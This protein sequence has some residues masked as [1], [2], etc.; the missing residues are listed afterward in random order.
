MALFVFTYVSHSRFFSWLEALSIR[1]M[2]EQYKDAGGVLLVQPEHL[3]S[4]QQMGTEYAMTEGKSAAAKTLNLT[5][6]FLFG[7][8]RDIV[9]ESDENF[10]VKFELVYTMGLQQSADNSP[11]RWRT[12]QEVLG[13]I[14]T[15]APEVHN[16]FPD[17]IEIHPGRPGSFSRTRVLKSEAMERL[18]DGL[19][20]RVC[21]EGIT[22]LPIPRQTPAVR[23][24]V[25]T[26][27]TK[28]DLTPEEINN[29][30]GP[31]GFSSDAVRPTLVLLRGLVVSNV[32]AFTPMQKRWRVNYGTAP[33]RKPETR[34]A[35]PYR[36]KGQPSPRSEF[37]HPDVVI[38][39]TCLSYY[40]SG[41]TDED[42][43]FSFDQLLRSD[44]AEI[45]YALWVRESCRM[46]DKFKTLAGV[47]T[48]DRYRCVRDVFPHL[49]FSKAVV[50][51]FLDNIV[52]PKEMKEFPSKLAAS[53]WD[54]GEKKA[55]PTTGFSGT[56][57]SRRLLPLG[58]TQLD[59]D[60]Q[61]HTNA[62]VMTYLLQPQ[63]SV[64]DIPPRSDTQT[65]DAHVLLDLV[66]SLEPPVRVI[67]DVGAQVLELSNAEVAREWL[68]KLSDDDGTQAVVFFNAEDE[69]SVVDRTGYT[70]R[71]QTSPFASQMEA[72][73]VFLDEA[74]TR[75]TDLKLPS[76][77][78]AAVTLG[79][80][81]TKDGLMQGN[82]HSVT[83]PNRYMWSDRG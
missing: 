9:D 29:V 62:L 12:I 79:A 69:L 20:S 63:T 1:R 13:L 70:E 72:C 68:R 45:E 51:Y 8:A 34:L 40:Y 65:S 53:G 19:V 21:D 28:M 59:L 23:D 75:G 25:R 3:L 49:R 14:R 44:Q 24:A 77:Y 58:M 46:P 50:D 60:D 42:L 76:D 35:V 33:D 38:I 81:Q 47:N 64:T 55:H 67:L 82:S 83:S 57:D 80:N 6:H 16:E 52:F 10:S 17:A 22:G 26:Y 43:F 7:S 48:E 66:I 2:L 18:L 71:L 31:D 36:A 74:H 78:R 54:L 37:S 15:V 27:I 56:N 30:E 41:L 4:L 5:R 39:L 73:L 32:L 11:Q 61:K